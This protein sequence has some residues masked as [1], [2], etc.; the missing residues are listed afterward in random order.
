[1]VNMHHKIKNEMCS[2]RNVPHTA[3]STKKKESLRPG[4]SA[5]MWLYFLFLFFVMLLTNSRS[6]IKM[7]FVLSLLSGII[8]LVSVNIDKQDLKIY[9]HSI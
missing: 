1:M 6:S 8:S 9:S 3:S 2:F 7:F 5:N 4:V